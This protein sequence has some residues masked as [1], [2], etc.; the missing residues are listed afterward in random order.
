MKFFRFTSLAVLF[1]FL[2]GSARAASAWT[3]LK[4]G[5]TSDDAIAAVGEPLQRSAGQGF[6][7]WIYDDCAELVFYG[8]L[9]GWTA[10][11]TAT[12]A[13]RSVDVWSA[14]AGAAMPPHI[15]PRP[16]ATAKPVA[17]LNPATGSA[18]PNYRRRY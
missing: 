17:M 5:M 15:L 12:A 16:G 11:R 2:T 10:P 7:I 3:H 13:A 9:V 4:L 14:P 8:P 18:L 1:V 6:E